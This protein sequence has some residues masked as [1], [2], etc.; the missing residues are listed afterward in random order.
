[1]ERH[2]SDEYRP[3][4][5]SRLRYAEFYQLDMITTNLARL[6][7]FRTSIQVAAVVKW[8]VRARQMIPKGLTLIK[9]HN[10]CYQ[11]QQLRRD[12]PV[13]MPSR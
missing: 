8:N 4:E 13:A 11:V 10:S 2:T 5:Q 6:Q 3:T 9:L 12:E 7:I 1:M